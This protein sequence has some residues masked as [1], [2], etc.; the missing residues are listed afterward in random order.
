MIYVVLWRC[1][2]GVLVW[3]CGGDAVVI[4]WWYEVTVYW[5]DGDSAV[6]RWWFDGGYAVFWCY[7]S[8]CFEVV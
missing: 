6:V 3:R 1:G 5:F 8:S 7:F 4:F 2:G